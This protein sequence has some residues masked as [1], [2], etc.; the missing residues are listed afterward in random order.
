MGMRPA[1]AIGIGVSWV[2]RHSSLH[3]VENSQNGCLGGTVAH[4]GSVCQ[5]R[6]LID[7]G[8]GTAHRAGRGELICALMAMLSS[9]TPASLSCSLN[10]QPN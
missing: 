9:L 7:N 8:R 1:V 10:A 5:P 2:L 4:D 3:G 6:S